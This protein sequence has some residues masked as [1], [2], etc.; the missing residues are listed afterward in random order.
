M[1]SWLLLSATGA[2]AE[3]VEPARALQQAQKQLNAEQYEQAVATLQSIIDQQ[4]QNGEAYR[5]L[6][7]ARF[8]Q[9]QT[10]QARRAFV[11]AMQWGRLT[12]AMLG[13]MV[14]IDRKQNQPLAAMGA[15]K[16]LIWLTPEQ[17]TWAVLY[18]Q[19]LRDMQ[20]LEAAA[21]VYD[22]LLET[23]PADAALMQRLGQVRL[24]Q[25]QT[26]KAR[27]LLSTAYY[28]GADTRELARLIG[29]LHAQM[30]QPNAA[31]HWYD[32]AARQGEGPMSVDQQLRRARLLRRVGRVEA[33]N[34][35]LEDMLDRTNQ[36]QRARVLRLLGHLAMDREASKQ[37]AEYWQKAVAAGAEDASLL[38][39]LGRHHFNAD[40]YPQAARWLSRFIETGTRDQAMHRALI[41]SL[42]RTD[43]VTAARS[44]MQGYLKHFGLDNQ[45]QQLIGQWR[46][47]SAPT[48]GRE[49]Q[50]ES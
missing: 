42:L 29:D 2:L 41:V 13:R 11:N 22:R 16:M 31:L 36:A 4:P 40:R 34:R 20:S 23:S 49:G 25:G 9:G 14:R 37:A 48:A 47:K 30:D 21:G 7:H 44:A 39:F 50:S 3:D 35:L 18:G 10:T 8:E 5:L 12:P 17:S 33:A 32:T 26:A 38:A 15:L 27:S 19:M 1:V 6:G 45:A 43:Q 46:R 28:L 24:E